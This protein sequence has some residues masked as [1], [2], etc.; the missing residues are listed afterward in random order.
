MSRPGPSD[1]IT[2][3]DRATVR[4]LLPEAL[5]QVDRL[6][7]VYRAMVHGRVENPPKI[8][9]HPRPSSFLHAMPAH[10]ADGDVTALKW[11]A[12][13]P[14]NPARG[15]PAVSG[16][17][18]LNDSGTGL[19]VAVMDAAEITTARTASASAVSIRHLAHPGWQRVAILGY[20]EQGR[21][22]AR[23]VRALNPGAAV[24]VHGGPRLAGPLPGVE[25]VADARTAVEGADVVVTAG[26]MAPDPTRRLERSWLADRVLVVPVDFSAYVGADVA[27]AADQLVTDDVEQL[28]HYRTLG[29]FEGWPAPH[30]S[31]GQ[32][33]EREPAGDL[34]VSCSLGVGAV[35]AA[36]AAVV[37]ERA[38]ERGEGLRLPR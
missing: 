22:H 37:H 26:P 5:E 23:V 21:A 16:L 31:L 28:E 20:G 4:G 6:A 3:L 32:A 19:P 36:L 34:R 15:V 29:H 35:D 30:H 2:Y 38:L 33:L 10:L 9:V 18:V 1:T 11:I 25:V 14:G 13:Y 27:G 8:G 24:R 12:A 17:V 7:A